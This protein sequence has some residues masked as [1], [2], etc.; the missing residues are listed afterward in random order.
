MTVKVER[1]KHTISSA[2][3]YQG[4]KLLLILSLFSV[5]AAFLNVHSL[6]RSCRRTINGYTPIETTTNQIIPNKFISSS[7]SSLGADGGE[8]NGS[9]VVKSNSS[10]AQPNKK[11]RKN[12]YKKKKG[13]NSKKKNGKK[14]TFLKSKITSNNNQKL[15]PLTELKLGAT[16]DGYVAS[17]T[18]FGIFMKTSYDFKDK[19]SNGYALLHKSQIR[20]ER[21]EDLTKLFRVGAK[22]R[23]LRVINI[24]YAK[25]EVGVSL[26]KKR[27]DRKKIADIPL[28]VEIEGTVANVLAYGAFV[29][30][31]ADANALL[32]ISR[33]S[34]KKVGNIR[35]VISEGEKVTVRI[36][37]KD[38]KKKTMAA[39]MLDKDADEYL[40]MRS[41]QMRKMKESSNLELES[42][43]TEIE[44]F[45]EAV[46][47]LEQTLAE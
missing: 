34:Q 36:L 35:D 41:K 32:H 23:G 39:S 3:R 10:V 13:I 30:V 47:E 14:K 46:R 18:P 2:I 6:Q 27:T 5:A 38:V 37:S 31:G 16:I 22:V 43:K 20:D 40:D 19:G 25:G 7:L 4:M 15:L 42:L 26:R 1:I 9:T 44:Y 17:F 45:E 12:N 29:D 33:I 28:G 8:V 11:K 21:V 24:N